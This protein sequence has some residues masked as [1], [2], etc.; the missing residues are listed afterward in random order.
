[1]SKPYKIVLLAQVHNEIRRGNLQRFVRHVFP[2]VDS[3][4]VY[5]DSSTDGSYE[6]LLQHTPYVI[7]GARNNFQHEIGSKQRALDLALTLSPDFILW[8]DTD[9]VLT[10]NAKQDLQ[11]LC[12]HCV[13]K[14]LDAI[15]L[16][17]LNLW[18]SG[19]WRR[20]DGAYDLGWFVRL[21][22]VTPGIRYDTTLRGLHQQQYPST[23]KI[24]ERSDLIE[25]LH[26]GFASDLAL[27]FKYIT[28]RFHGQAGWDLDRLLDEQGRLLDPVPSTKFPP[29]LITN[30]TEPVPRLF[31]AAVGESETLG[32]QILTPSI[33][34]LF[35]GSH[36]E[37]ELAADQLIEHAARL[38]EEVCVGSA[39]LSPE[40]ATRFRLA[41]VAHL[42]FPPTEQPA[43]IEPPPYERLIH[44]TSGDVVFV[45]TSAS[46]LS[47]E[48]THE[49]FTRLRKGSRA[50]LVTHDG[51][52]NGVMFYAS[53]FSPTGVGGSVTDLAAFLS[54]RLK[55]GVA[56]DSFVPSVQ[57]APRQP[58]DVLSETGRSAQQVVITS[59]P[60]QSTP[61]F[62][63]CVS[64]FSQNEGAEGPIV[65]SLLNQTFPEWEA[66]LYTPPERASNLER[67]LESDKRFRIVATNHYGES[68]INRSAPFRGRWII[69]LTFVDL[70]FPDSLAKLAHSLHDE[71][72]ARIILG[73]PCPTEVMLTDQERSWSNH[74]HPC[75]AILRLA[76]RDMMGS[77]TII[78]RNHNGE[79]PPLTA[80]LYRFD[81][82]Y[83][84][85]ATVLK[86]GAWRALEYPFARSWCDRAFRDRGAEFLR[87]DRS[88]AAIEFLNRWSLTNIFEST[89]QLSAELL[90][91]ILMKLLQVSIDKNALLHASVGYSA[92]LLG[93]LVEWVTSCSHSDLKGVLVRNLQAVCSS[94]MATPELPEP[95]R[96][97]FQEA[98]RDLNSNYLFVPLPTKIVLTDYLD[99]TA[100][101]EHQSFLR[102][103]LRL[104]PA[105]EH[106]AADVG[107]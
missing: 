3:V 2:L 11:A 33:S 94:V 9:E 47:A 49:L 8:L 56:L 35:T 102:D 66:I 52:T 78:L 5:D 24:I 53:D 38:E 28:Y 10:N 43:S 97:S 77:G 16:H 26:Y 67:M 98:A 44:Q 29:E 68:L 60:A 4:V 39:F 96:Q 23:I 73:T 54:L 71:T 87:F 82:W 64:L 6:Y 55:P 22:R 57:V 76:S 89:P 91:R 51:R 1:M 61:L 70:L 20:V 18:R 17:E 107:R 101:L 36:H 86:S 21:W 93:R 46:A 81:P 40:L 59:H 105:R 7:R 95:L 13:D 99:S 103:Y 63:L 80:G 58:K 37:I 65:Q 32:T 34:I 12:Q 31:S 30:E 41:G 69:P 90:D 42:S 75:E 74:S 92:A 79:D 14:E 45:A 100:V 104:S 25:V 48:T 85:A 72:R 62:T 83:E 84:H 50:S 15:S 27:A 106:T 88:R 19:C